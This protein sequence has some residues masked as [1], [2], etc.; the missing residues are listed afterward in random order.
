MSLLG[1]GLAY[2]YQGSA[3]GGIINDVAGVLWRFCEA[4]F[5]GCLLVEGIRQVFYQTC[6]GGGTACRWRHDRI[7][8]LQANVTQG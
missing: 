8:A 2:F 7:H 3:L 4:D 6:P 5:G 1:Q